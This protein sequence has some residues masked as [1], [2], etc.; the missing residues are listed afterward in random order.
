MPMKGHSDPTLFKR[1]CLFLELFD[2]QKLPP[3]FA[4]RKD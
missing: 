3:N 4:G 2:S 1:A